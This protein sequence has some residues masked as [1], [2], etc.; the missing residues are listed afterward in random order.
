LTILE[1]PK[2][3]WGVL[4]S[5]YCST[6]FYSSNSVIP[7]SDFPLVFLRSWTDTLSHSLHFS[8]FELAEYKDE[9]KIKAR[10]DPTTGIVTYDFIKSDPSIDVVV[11]SFAAQTNCPNMNGIDGCLYGEVPLSYVSTD[12]FS[13]YGRSSQEFQISSGQDVV[14]YLVVR[15][16]VCVDNDFNFSKRV[17]NVEYKKN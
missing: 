15:P 13:E 3:P 5:K 16:G 17:Q 11:R 10:S 8:S 14:T 9:V 1:Y 7:D 4:S 6:C 2:E 12:F